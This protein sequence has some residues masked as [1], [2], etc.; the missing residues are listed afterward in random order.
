MTASTAGITLL[1]PA[2]GSG[3][4]G[5]AM[6]LTRALSNID[7][8]VEPFKAVAVV[9]PGDP[10]HDAVAPWQRGALHNCAAA[11]R[12]VQPWH[13]PVSVVR[14]TAQARRGELYVWGGAVGEVRVSHDD[15][16][17]LSELPV[18][19]RRVCHDAIGDACAHLR[20][21][22]RFVVAEGGG[23]AGDI[24]AHDDLANHLV[25]GILG[26][27]VVLVLNAARSGQTAALIGL[28]RLLAPPISTL[29]V[30]CVVNQ[31]R[32]EEHLATTSDRLDGR[33]GLPVLAVVDEVQ[34]PPEYDGSDAECDRLYERR[35]RQVVRSGLLDAVRVLGNRGSTT[36]K[37]EVTT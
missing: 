30:G 2:A 15:L 32:D 14:E 6:G 27:P 16:L 36:T 1:A 8:A 7:V 23:A 10:A 33:T 35:A 13:A 19:L 37:S 29:L 20:A 34:Q 22:D 4:T 5:I 11:R 3:K 25:P 26:L 28:L 31:V 17:D 21:A 24:K 18:R 9:A 12:Q